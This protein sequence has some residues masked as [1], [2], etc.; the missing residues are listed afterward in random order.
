MKH[1]K[2][3]KVIKV[4]SAIAVGISSLTILA[5]LLLLQEA[6]RQS[7]FMPDANYYQSSAC[8]S[9]ANKTINLVVWNWESN[10]E[11]FA[12]QTDCPELLNMDYWIYDSKH[13]L[14]FESVTPNATYG[15][16][17][18]FIYSFESEN[19]E[20]VQDDILVRYA[21]KTPLIGS[22]DFTRSAEFFYFL[23][24]SRTTFTILMVLAAL[25]GIC[26][27]IYL[28]ISI[29]PDAKGFF[30]RIF[31]RIPIEPIV[32]VGLFLGIAGLLWSASIFG[33]KLYHW[34][35]S[36]RWLAFIPIGLIAAYCFLIVWM[37]VLRQYRQGQL[38]NNTLLRRLW[39]LYLRL[40]SR[41]KT[42]IAYAALIILN[43]FAFS[44]ENFLFALICILVDI[45]ILCI[46]LRMAWAKD[47]LELAAM[48]LANGEMKAC[49]DTSKM[50]GS[51][52]RQGESLNQAKRSLQIA[53]E[54]KLKSE[55]MRSELLTNVSH[56]FKTPLTSILSYVELLKKEGLQ[57][58]AK[59]YCAVLERQ[60][61]RLKKLT[62][63]VIMASKAFSGNLPVSLQSTDLKEMI[64]QAIAEYDQPFKA[65]QL[66]LIYR[67]SEEP[68]FILADGN[69]L[70]RIINNLFHNV[71]KYAL[72]HTRVYLEV[73][74]SS[75]SI[76]VTVKNISEKRLELS[77]EQLLER[78]VQGD[79]SRQ[80]EGSGLGLSIASSLAELQG[81]NLTI[82]IDGDLF[83]ACL[84]LPAFTSANTKADSEK[85]LEA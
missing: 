37:L 14:L 59:D 80:T 13:N 57:G 44:Y 75:E 11:E 5:C 21:V 38:W 1:E 28:S 25:I 3:S 79:T 35:T 63:D 49:V 4:L 60:A 67:L 30:H 76:T 17:S 71:E 18:E 64:E 45:G 74:Q 40:P 65:R 56:D 55:R 41:W 22:D 72:E 47:R 33:L 19:S 66:Q 69:L 81:G 15:Y 27:V 34:E 70:W 2:R 53:L 43:A 7:A 9:I 51:L 73:Q 82:D 78:F 36:L 20:T 68:I 8:G 83:K 46:L 29:R 58:N 48:S 6:N 10:P 50:F 39:D 85:N 31:D 61:L 12:S 62:D 23:A 26:S 24:N 77:E 32:I 52:K 16:Q 42:I 84:T 54:E